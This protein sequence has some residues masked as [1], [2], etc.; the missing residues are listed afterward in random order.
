MVRPTDPLFDTILMSSD[1]T[2]DTMTSRSCVKC[3][4]GREAFWFFWGARMYPQREH[5]MDSSEL[6]APLPLRRDGRGPRRVHHLVI[7]ENTT[8][9][10][11]C[12]L[13]AI[14]GRFSNFQ[15]AT[16]SK[17]PRCK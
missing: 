9:S 3:L 6:P 1:R 16:F 15:E 7:V 2:N 14:F 8:F 5:L 10:E 13:N 12:H 11:K 17:F 4:D